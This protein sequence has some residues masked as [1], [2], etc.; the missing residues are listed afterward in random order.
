M[1]SLTPAI[2]HEFL[3]Y[4]LYNFGIFFLRSSY[5]VPHGEVAAGG[6]ADHGAPVHGYSGDG[7]GG[8]EDEDCLDMAP[9]I[10]HEAEH[11]PV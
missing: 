11:C 6:Q 8:D 4:E 3:Q 10:M 9:C 1:E 7:E 5:N 2:L